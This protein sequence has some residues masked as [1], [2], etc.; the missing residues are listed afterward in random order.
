[1]FTQGA[2]LGNIENLVLTVGESFCTNNDLNA[3]R[4]GA[5]CTMQ[6]G[7]GVFHHLHEL[8]PPLRE[9]SFNLKG[10]G[11]MVFFGAKIFFFRI[12]SQNLFFRFAAQRKK[13]KVTT[14]HDLIFFLPKQ[15]F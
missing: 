6:P 1:M 12:R 3:D 10:G 2:G 8:I 15:V 14:C 11:A 9:H 7:V 4:T 5:D 13:L